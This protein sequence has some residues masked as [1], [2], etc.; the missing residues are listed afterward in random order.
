MQN[1]AV[2]DAITAA[3][4]LLIIGIGTNILGLTKIR[5]GN[6]IPALVYAVLWTVF[7]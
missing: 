1:A 5:I 3:G 7:I 4:G 6:F 2:I